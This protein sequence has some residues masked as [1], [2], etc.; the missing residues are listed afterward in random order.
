VVGIVSFSVHRDCRDNEFALFT[1]VP[2][3]VVW[4]DKEINEGVNEWILE[5]LKC[6]FDYNVDHE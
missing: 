2:K 1:N 5:P 3:F 6:K 4:I